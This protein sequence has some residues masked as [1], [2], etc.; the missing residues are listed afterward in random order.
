MYSPIIKVF[1]DLVSPYASDLL[2]LLQPSFQ[3][4]IAILSVYSMKLM[5]FRAGKF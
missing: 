1:F 3:T 5:L 4:R 2:G